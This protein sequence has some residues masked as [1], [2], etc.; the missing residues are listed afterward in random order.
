MEGFLASL[1]VRGVTLVL[2]PGEEPVRVLVERI[3]PDQGEFAVA[4]ETATGARS[5]SSAR[6]SGNLKSRSAPCSAVQKPP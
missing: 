4:R 5:T 1:S 3:E 2:L 6:T